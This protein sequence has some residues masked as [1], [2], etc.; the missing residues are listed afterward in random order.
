M[1]P[2]DVVWG[3]VEVPAVVWGVV[4]GAAVDEDW[5]V[6]GGAEVLGGRAEV[7]VGCAVVV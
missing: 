2:A 1:V 7:V 6:V 4:V 3:V 5:A